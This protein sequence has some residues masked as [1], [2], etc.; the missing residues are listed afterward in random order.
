MFVVSTV[1]KEVFEEK[2][3]Y[4]QRNPLVYIMLDELNK[5]AP[6]TGTS[7]IKDILLDI[8]ERGRSLGMILIGAQQ[9]ASE[10]EKRIYANSAVKIL[11]RIDP[12]EIES[13]EYGYLSPLMRKRSIL[14]PPGE[15]ILHQPDIPYPL[16][17][18]FPFPAWATNSEEVFTQPENSK[19]ERILLEN[20]LGDFKSSPLV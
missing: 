16:I 5:Y 1:I 7:P 4:G 19:D 10:V 18:N 20:I 3:K 17:L 6:K 13:S 2:E 8:A 15:L 12:G 9:T 14:S 11:G